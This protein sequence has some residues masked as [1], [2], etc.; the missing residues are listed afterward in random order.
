ME[1]SSNYKNKIESLLSSYKLNELKEIS[2]SLS[3]NYESNVGENKEFISSKLEALVYAVTRMPSTYSS[4]Y[5]ALSYINEFDIGDIT[6][7]S[8]IGSGTGAASLASYDTFSL[9]EIN[10]YERNTYMR[11][12][13]KD[14]IKDEDI[15]NITS[16]NEFDLLKDEL[17]SKS[18]LVISSYVL[19]ELSKIDRREA[20]LK[21][22]HATNKILLIVEPG[23][24]KGYQIILEAR[25]LLTDNNGYILAPCP[26]QNTCPM[27]DNDWC[28]FSTRVSRSKMH[29]FLKGGDVPYEDEKFSY[30]AISKSNYGHAKNRILRHPIIN[31]AL[32]NLTL[33]SESGIKNIDVRKNDVNYKKARKSG[34]GDSY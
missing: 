1:L 30:I 12:V 25:K 29:K 11:E 19:N 17:S 14:I 9:E 10:C 27:K 5:K 3:K 34:S 32:V 20:L 22:W 18:D 13:N 2:L 33:C 8:D 7:L 26:H 24:P 16:L 6:S 4:I 23:T 28:H 15:A 21:M 31:K